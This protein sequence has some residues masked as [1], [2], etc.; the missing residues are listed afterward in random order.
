MEETLPF[1]YWNAIGQYVAGED[2]SASEKR[3]DKAATK[4]PPS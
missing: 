4:N 1:S 3:G 2:P